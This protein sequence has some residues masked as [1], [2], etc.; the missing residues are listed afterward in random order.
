MCHVIKD[1]I[2]FDGLG[3]S[4]SPKPTLECKSRSYSFSGI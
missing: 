4:E 2:I 1:L 3:V